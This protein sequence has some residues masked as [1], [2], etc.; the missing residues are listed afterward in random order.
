M[1]TTLTACAAACEFGG[2][3][4]GAKE[5]G[6]QMRGCLGS[7]CGEGFAVLRREDAGHHY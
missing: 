6:V 4:A 5:R 1:S 3:G 2:G 7:G